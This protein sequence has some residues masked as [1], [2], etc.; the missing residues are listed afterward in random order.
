LK[1]IKSLAFY[2]LLWLRGLFLLIS[3]FLTGMLL[4]GAIV[5][6]VIGGEKV[7]VFMLLAHSFAI[8]LLAH[9]YDRLLLWLNP[10]GCDLTLYQ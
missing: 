4:L 3:N 7:V 10:T 8:F 9:F 2:P 6:W 1:I 5:C